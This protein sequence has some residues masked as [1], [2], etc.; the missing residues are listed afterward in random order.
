MKFLKKIFLPIHYAMSGFSF[1]ISNLYSFICDIFIK[2]NLKLTRKEDT[3]FQRFFTKQKDSPENLLLATLYIVTIISLVNIFVP[4]TN[5]SFSDQVVIFNYQ[6]VNTID[7]DDTLD[8]NSTDTNESV[9]NSQIYYNTT[10]DFTSLLER[11]S[12]TIAYITVEGTNISYPVVQTDNNDYY[13]DHDFDHNYSQKG[14][15]FADFR[16]TFDNLSLNTIIYGHHR[17]DNTMFGPLDILFTDDYY[18]RSSHNIILTTIS[19]TYTFRVFSVYE[20]DPEIYYLTTSFTSDNAYLEFLNTL[21]SRSLYQYNENFDV[22]SKI[23]TLSTCNNDNTGR[24]VVHAKLVGE[25]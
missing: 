1:T 19:K 2:I 4:K 16:N 23:I 20:I 10:V 3:K 22:N 5:N 12:D 9:N 11:N 18:N 8:N 15:I 6:N 21:K 25:S 13:L 24:L 14:A 17:L 7:N